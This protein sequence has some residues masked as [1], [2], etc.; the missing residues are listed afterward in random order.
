[1]FYLLLLCCFRCPV[2][3]GDIKSSCLIKYIAIYRTFWR[4]NSKAP[5]I[6]SFIGYRN[7]CLHYSWN[8]HSSLLFG[9]PLVITVFL[10]I[11]KHFLL[12]KNMY[13]LILLRV[14]ILNNLKI[15]S[16]I[17]HRSHKTNILDIVLDRFSYSELPNLSRKYGQFDALTS[18]IC[19]GS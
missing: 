2:I 10:I 9:F 5:N 19:V 14:K 13:F 4:A 6:L 18:H 17:R 12:Q 16:P 15:C 7:E 1:M 11:H 8:L 3:S